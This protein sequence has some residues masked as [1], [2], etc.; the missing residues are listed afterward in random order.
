MQKSSFPLRDFL[1]GV[2][3]GAV[4][5]MTSVLGADAAQEPM[6]AC[7]YRHTLAI[8]SDGTLWAWGKNVYGELGQ[9]YADV[10]S[11]PTPLKVGSARNW[12]AVA[13]GRNHSLG[14]QANGTLWAWGD[15][16][17]DVNPFLIPTRVGNA[18]NWVALAAGATHSLGIRSDGTLW[19]WGWNTYGQLGLGISDQKV[20]TAT[21]V[22][23]GTNWLAVASSGGSDGS[24][25]DYSLAIRSDG[26]LWAWGDNS[27]GEL[28]QGYADAN[29][30][31]S[32]IQVGF[33]NNWA[34]IAGGAWHCLGLRS[35]G[36]LWAW[37][38]NDQGE[39]G[40]GN[41]TVQYYSPT[42]VAIGTKWRTMAAGTRDSLAIR[43][44][45]TLWSWGA[46]Y[47]GELGLG[48]DNERDAPNKMGILTN[49]I[50][51]A[52]GDVYSLGLRSD[53]TLWSCGFNNLGQ[54]GIGNTN[55]DRQF[56]FVKIAGT[57]G[58]YRFLDRALPWLMLLLN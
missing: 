8:G 24:G 31:L 14:L 38:L 55:P 36:S 25:G 48:H 11:H 13:A 56:S 16:L 33:A 41:N 21:Q 30:H 28:G 20:T 6:I 42:Q 58:T 39:I 47:Y 5:L 43:S 22:W 46:N 44:D 45:G 51:V 19:A 29:Q 50:A 57:Y 4:I 52:A 49:W 53:R 26:T 17:L 32:P 15:T 7:G 35:D 40:Q 10:N 1:M 54:L 37:G 18:S 9:G 3:A 2:L 12:V 23:P 27:D 34:A